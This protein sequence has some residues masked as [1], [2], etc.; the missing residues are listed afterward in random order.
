MNKDNIVSTESV[1]GTLIDVLLERGDCIIA[2]KV[3]TDLS[4]IS[5]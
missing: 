1:H 4:S 5:F 3:Q 2:Q